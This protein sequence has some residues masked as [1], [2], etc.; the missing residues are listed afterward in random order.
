MLSPEDVLLNETPIARH[1]MS[2]NRFLVR[3]TLEDPQ[4]TC[5][6]ATVFGCLQ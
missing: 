3:E 5:S 4:T 6:I 1:G 2:M